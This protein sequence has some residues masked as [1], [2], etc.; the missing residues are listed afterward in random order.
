MSYLYVEDGIRV[1]VQN[2]AIILID[3]Q[4]KL[5]LNHLATNRIIIQP[6]LESLKN[7]VEEQ[8]KNS[9]KIDFFAAGK[10]LEFLKK[11]TMTKEERAKELAK[12]ALQIWGKPGDNCGG[13]GKGNFGNDRNVC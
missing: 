6:N 12:A 8:I 1:G 5:D 2:I 4:S 11:E 9:K 7:L 10:L 3:T 13:G